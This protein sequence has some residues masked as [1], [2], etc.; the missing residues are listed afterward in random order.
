MNAE[1]RKLIRSLIVLVEQDVRELA[2]SV[3]EIDERN[4]GIRRRFAEHDRR[5][6]ELES[7]LADNGGHSRKVEP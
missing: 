7:I 1:T 5:I 3:A 4:P 6:A 2:D